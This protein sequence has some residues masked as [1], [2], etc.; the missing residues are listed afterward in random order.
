M[1]DS[2]VL[3]RGVVKSRLMTGVRHTLSRHRPRRRAIQYSEALVIEPKGRSVLD[4]PLSRGMTVIARS[5]SH[6]TGCA[7]NVKPRPL[8]AT[9]ASRKRTQSSDQYPQ[10]LTVRQRKPN[11]VGTRRVT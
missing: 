4:T 5:G 9:G 2:G 10:T 3:R 6:R 1:H 8:A 11:G 7:N